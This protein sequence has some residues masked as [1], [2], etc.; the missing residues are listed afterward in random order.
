MIEMF[1]SVVQEKVA[2]QQNRL[3]HGSGGVEPGLHTAL[4][5]QPHTWGRD[6]PT[7]LRAGGDRPWVPAAGAQVG[8][9]GG[10]SAAGCMWLGWSFSGSSRNA[11]GW[12]AWLLLIFGGC[13]LV[14][15]ELCHCRSLLEDRLSLWLLEVKKGVSKRLAECPILFCCFCLRAS[16]APD[17]FCNGW[18]FTR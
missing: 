17:G 9:S 1:L 14:A 10:G 8:P 12:R 3:I 5:H 16:G 4:G 2:N 6:G 13:M 18:S 11:L 7:W 15:L